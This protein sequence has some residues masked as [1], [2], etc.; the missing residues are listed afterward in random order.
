MLHKSSKR[1]LVNGGSRILFANPLVKF[2]H[3]I[4]KFTTFLAQ[5]NKHCH[6]VVDTTF[7]ERGSAFKGGRHSAIFVNPL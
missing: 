7:G 2:T 6:S 3:G 4:R 5:S 1:G